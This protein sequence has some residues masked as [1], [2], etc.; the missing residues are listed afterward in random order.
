MEISL[1]RAFAELPADAQQ[2]AVH[3]RDINPFVCDLWLKRFEEFLC[4]GDEEVIYIVAHNDNLTHAILPLILTR[5]HK[6]R[7]RKLH[8]MANFYTTVFEPLLSD[9]VNQAAAA[10]AIAT[11]LA[12]EFKAIPL[13][14][15]EPLRD[16]GFMD[17][18]AASHARLSG[19]QVGRYVKHLNRYEPV[20]GDTYESYL[21]RRPGKLRSTIKRKK[22]Q[23]EKSTDG[24]ITIYETA[25]DVAREYPKFR[26]VYAQSW[27]GEESYPDF[28][29][30]VLSDL[31]GAGKAKLGILSIEN[32]PAAA[33]IWFRLGS[34]WGVFKLAYQ[35]Q[36]KQFSVGTLLTA[37]MI[38]SFFVGEPVSAIDFFSGDD[39]YKKDWVGE[40]REHFGLEFIHT[41]NIIGKILNTKRKLSRN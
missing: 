21:A 5:H 11:C 41:D 12:S 2:L 9:D 34:T 18:I 28:I 10:E 38:E 8:S 24:K 27:K 23:L 4:Q 37:A 36:Y 20:D 30:V 6:L 15:I 13:C 14:E 19:Q 31:A 40:C 7:F 35:P 33:Q 39:G 3:Y 32:Q 22:K 25:E 29:G 1:F 17:Q 16:P 26:N